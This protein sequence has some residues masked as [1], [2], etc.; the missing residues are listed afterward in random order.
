MS[1]VVGWFDDLLESLSARRRAHSLEV[2][3]KA[4]AVVVLVPAWLRSDLVAA[5]ILHDIGYAHRVTGFHALDGA[6]FLAEQGFS[7][8][9]CALVAFHSAS[10][11]EA[12]VRGIDAA[13]FEDFAVDVDLSA[14]HSVL[15]W[16]D[17]TT[18]PTG[19]TVTVEDRLAE[20]L[21]RYGSDDPVTTFITKARPLLL[22]AGQSPM[23]SI[24]D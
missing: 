2:G 17:M 3:R 4:A 23:G 16:A 14:G 13:V 18:G 21:G 19:A 15:A 22:A 10:P 11:V 24:Q 12:E 9:V 5:A 1:C 8:A 7:S 20:I 6:R